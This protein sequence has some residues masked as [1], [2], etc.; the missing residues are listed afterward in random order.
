ML[1]LEQTEPGVVN[2]RCFIK[3]DHQGADPGVAHEGILAAALSDAMALAHGADA[4]PAWLV[5]E[6]S[7]QAPVGAFID[8]QARVEHTTGTSATA[9]VGGQVVARARG[10]YPTS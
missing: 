2:G 9:S 7:G 4:R 3:Q 10:S 1:E 8:V 6:L 5:V